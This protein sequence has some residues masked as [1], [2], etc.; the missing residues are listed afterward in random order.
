M[1]GGYLGSFGVKLHTFSNLDKLYTKMKLLLRRLGKS[2]FRGQSRSSDLKLGVFGVI[3]GQ[4]S[5]IFKQG[6]IIYENE[7]LEPEITKSF[8]RSSEVDRLKVGGYLGSVGVKIKNY[9][10]PDKLYTKMKLLLT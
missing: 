6:Q 8:S 7:A 1:G 9:S 5:K 10:N 2:G 3:W 4:T